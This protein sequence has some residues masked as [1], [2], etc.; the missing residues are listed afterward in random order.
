[1]RFARRSGDTRRR[2][3]VVADGPSTPWRFPRDT[4]TDNSSMTRRCVRNATRDT[5]H[6]TRDEDEDEDEDEKWM[7]FALRVMR[8]TDR[9]RK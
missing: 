6:A 5:R 3:D 8:L 2:V 1:M 4:E 9:S 7:E